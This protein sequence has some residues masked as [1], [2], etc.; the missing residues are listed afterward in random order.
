LLRRPI[1]A[2]FFLPAARR[3]F[4]LCGSLF[5][6]LI[7]EIIDVLLST[8]QLAGMF[9]SRFGIGHQ[10]ESFFFGVLMRI[11]QSDLELVASV[12]TWRR[13]P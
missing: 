6:V 9:S 11:E 4:G 12:F 5:V 1:D 2:A 3:S 7:A 13:F 10:I 8:K